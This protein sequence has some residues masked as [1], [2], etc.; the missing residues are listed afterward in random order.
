MFAI[1]LFGIA[2]N[3]QR[4][5]TDTIKGNET[6]VF[7]NMLDAKQIQVKCTQIGGTSEGTMIMKA[8]VDGIVFTTVQETAGLFVFFPNDTLTI[9]NNATWLINIK[10]KPFNYFRLESTGGTGDTTK[11]DVKWAK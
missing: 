10:D 2:N 7:D 6:I 8:S 11:I 5:V 9:L 4:L 3:A 1:L